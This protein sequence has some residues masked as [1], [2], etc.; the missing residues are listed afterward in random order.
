M[1]VACLV[2]DIMDFAFLEML[3]LCHIPFLLRLEEL[4]AEYLRIPRFLPNAGHNCM[5][6]RSTYFINRFKLYHYLLVLVLRTSECCARQILFWV[7]LF[8]RPRDLPGS[9]PP[10]KQP[11]FLR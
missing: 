8:C 5:V 7:K 9:T 10:Q 2:F 4:H 3:L 1:S 6:R 11:I